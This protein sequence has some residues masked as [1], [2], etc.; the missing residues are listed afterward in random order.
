MP[1]ALQLSTVQ[2]Y[3]A[4]AYMQ[5]RSNIKLILGD[6]GVISREPAL[7]QHSRAQSFCSSAWMHLAAHQ[8]LE[9]TIGGVY[10]T[11]GFYNR[12]FKSFKSLCSGEAWSEAVKSTE[13]IFSYDEAYLITWKTL[14]GDSYLQ[15]I[16]VRLSNSAS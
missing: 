13:N 2:G 1:G 12:H 8:I 5:G 15:E 7:N 16:D 14:T 10:N 6:T 4:V 3:I 11:S 9:D